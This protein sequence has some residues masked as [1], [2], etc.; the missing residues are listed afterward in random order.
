MI[1][2]NDIRC[3]ELYWQ[4]KASQEMLGSKAYEEAVWKVSVC[5]DLWW[6]ELHRML[7]KKQQTIFSQQQTGNKLVLG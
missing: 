4:R 7:D 3:K 2:L 6:D 5:K 1:T